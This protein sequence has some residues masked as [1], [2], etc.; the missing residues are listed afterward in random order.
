MVLLYCLPLVEGGVKRS[1]LHFSHRLA[2]HVGKQARECVEG[3]V[4]ATRFHEEE[5]TVTYEVLLGLTG[6]V[7]FPRDMVSEHAFD[8]G[9]GSLEVHCYRKAGVVEAREKLELR[10]H[11]EEEFRS[12]RRLWTA[13]EEGEAVGEIGDYWCQ[14]TVVLMEPVRRSAGGVALQLPGAGFAS[15]G[16]TPTLQ[17]SVQ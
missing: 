9:E 10:A 15:F 8:V 7:D 11:L 17:Q 5:K 16:R 13:G 4:L 6:P 2:D 1:S 14:T 3:V 12:S